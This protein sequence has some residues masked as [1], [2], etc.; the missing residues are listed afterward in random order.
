MP[1]NIKFYQFWPILLPFSYHKWPTQ[2]NDDIK[3]SSTKIIEYPPCRT[4][5]YEAENDKIRP[6]QAENKGISKHTY[7]GEK[8]L[9]LMNYLYLD[10]AFGYIGIENTSSLSEPKANSEERQQ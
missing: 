10:F 2:S 6:F 5:V 3:Q 7:Y 8:H 9:N 1:K 4:T